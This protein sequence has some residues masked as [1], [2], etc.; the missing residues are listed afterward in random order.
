MALRSVRES[1]TGLEK[2][3]GKMDSFEARFD[4]IAERSRKYLLFFS[5]FHPDS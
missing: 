5:C 3:V 1:K 4:K 2:L